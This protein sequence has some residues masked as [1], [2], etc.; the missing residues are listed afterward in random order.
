MCTLGLKLKQHL[1]LVATQI[2]TIK[3]S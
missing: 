3:P 2:S 1:S